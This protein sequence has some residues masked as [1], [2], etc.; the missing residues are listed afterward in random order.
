MEEVV[1]EKVDLVEFFCEKVDLLEVKDLMLLEQ[2]KVFLGFEGQG[3][4]G[5]K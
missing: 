1:L 2:E 4:S 5:R 3:Y